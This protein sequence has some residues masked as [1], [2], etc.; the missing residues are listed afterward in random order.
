MATNIASS[1]DRDRD[2][3]LYEYLLTLT[4]VDRDSEGRYKESEIAEQWGMTDNRMFVR[5][6]VRSLEPEKYGNSEIPPIPGITLN[7]LVHILSS[8]E[9]YQIEQQDKRDSTKLPKILTRQ[10]KLKALRLYAQLSVE[11]RKNINLPIH[12][13]EL[14]LNKLI[15]EITDPI[16]GL[17]S[18]EVIKLHQH[19]QRYLDDQVGNEWTKDYKINL[20][21]A[22]NVERLLATYQYLPSNRLD[23]L[24]NK[25][26]KKVENALHDI[27]YQNGS[28]ELRLFLQEHQLSFRSSI[29]NYTSSTDI[30]NKE[31]NIANR[32]RQVD[33]RFNP[34]NFIS[35]LTR[36]IVNNELLNEEFPIY[37]NYIES[38]EI[39]PLPLPENELEVENPTNDRV[40]DNHQVFAYTVKVHFYYIQGGKRT[41]FYEEVTGVGS[42]LSHAIA[43]INRV[44][45]WDIPSLKDYIPIAKEITIENKI[46]ANSTNGSVWSHYLV[47]LCKREA[48][49]ESLDK[50]V[51]AQGSEAEDVFSP[52][53]EINE[54]EYCGF[55][56]LESSVKAAFYARL[57]AIQRTGIYSNNSQKYIQELAKKISQSEHLRKAGQLLNSYPFSL[58][59]M[60]SYLCDNLFKSN[61]NSCYDDDEYGFPIIGT[62]KPSEEWTLNEYEAYLLLTESYL[63]EGLYLIGKNYLDCIKS[64][65]EKYDSEPIN[66]IILARYHL[67]NFRYHYLTDLNDSTNP[68]G[69]RSAA[70]ANAHWSLNEAYKQ[71][72]MYIYKCELMDE[73]PHINFSDF[74]TLMSKLYA[75]RAKLFF[76]MSIYQQN[77]SI[78]EPIALF[79]KA[80]MYAAR[81]GNPS[82]YA[83]W[84]AYQSWCSLVAAYDEYRDRQHQYIQKAKKLLNLALEAYIKPGQSYYESIKIASGKNK[85]VTYG[86]IEIQTIP[87]IQE[88]QEYPDEKSKK[89]DILLYLNTK[90]L[91]YQE[92]YL[93]GTQSSMLIFAKGMLELCQ[94]NPDLEKAKQNFIYSWSFAEDGLYRDEKEP[95]RLHRFYKNSEKDQKD[96]KNDR[97]PLQDVINHFFKSENLELAGLYPHRLTQFADFGKVYYVVCELISLLSDYSDAAVRESRWK[98]I[99]KIL[100]RLKNNT[101]I[102]KK[103]KAEQTKYNG[104]LEDC[105]QAIEKYVNSFENKIQ[106]SQKRNLIDIR[107]I[108][109]TEINKIM[110]TGQAVASRLHQG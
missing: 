98:D 100:E 10:E 40:L 35:R 64:H 57:R 41:D 26:T 67:C 39:Q 4:D 33:R 1:P 110:R 5:R 18:E 28:G 23:E 27:G 12:E 48:I 50:L 42:P 99:Q 24:K 71:L 52:V 108:V 56:L 91:H 7:R 70:I 101:V 80:R 92:T 103:H 104:H 14:L 69:N 107:D 66:K 87:T 96:R 77:Q 79:E 58:E 62:L 93:F 76:L 68:N 16:N 60:K 73:L 19:I 49:K 53:E 21:I 85:Y 75:H 2:R 43:A 31:R 95:N 37:L 20:Q 102:D 54:G 106:E 45:L 105:F 90:D 32:N 83:M 97:F 34:P 81:S 94:E 78:S 6:V 72:K 15:E 74:F 84:T 11:E 25:I 44:L 36:S 109:V 61:D 3:K 13:S 30:E 29:I 89:S 22:E 51:Q 55:D 8:I 88:V 46:V 86:N 82:L 38:E 63:K 65:I 47:G 17:N 9:K 59:A